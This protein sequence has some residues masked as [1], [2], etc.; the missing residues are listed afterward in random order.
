QKNFFNIKIFK[1]LLD[2]ITTLLTDWIMYISMFLTYET[3]KFSWAGIFSLI[4]LRYLVFDGHDFF[5]EAYGTL[6]KHTPFPKKIIRTIRG[7]GIAKNLFPEYGRLAHKMGADYHAK[8]LVIVFFYD[9]CYKVKI[10]AAFKTISV[11]FYF[12]VNLLAI[13]YI[14]ALVFFQKTHVEVL[15]LITR[16]H[17]VKL[18]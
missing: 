17:V 9:L 13:I 7:E 14:V 11:V 3:H 12:Y 6:V 4:L 8:L 10:M 18:I 2:F 16:K 1:F 15:H 5:V